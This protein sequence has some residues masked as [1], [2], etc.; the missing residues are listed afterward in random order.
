MREFG[1]IRID[2]EPGGEYPE[3][4]YSAAERAASIA[5]LR[6]I[7][8]AAVHQFREDGFLSVEALLSREDVADALAGLT[9]LATNPSGA[10]VEFESWAAAKLDEVEGEERLDFVRKFHSFV[11]HEERLQRLAMDPELL[12]AVRRMLG[13]EDV[14]LFQDMALLKPPGG[15]R[16]KPF[17]QDHGFFDFKLGTPMVGVWIALD[18]A[19]PE[20]VCMHVVRGSHLEGPVIHF[21]RRDFQICDTSV[22]RSRLVSAPL[23]PGGGLFFDGLLHH[24]TPANRTDRRRRALQFHYVPADALT[25]PDEERLAV[26]GSEGKDVAC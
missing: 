4:L 5:S 17:H 20:N 3:D 23:P 13:A 15:G 10:S 14:V 25:V 24:G 6:D 7:D 2:E 1:S 16:E 8:D 11:D 26:F 22:D 12:R 21:R 9:S 18:E 19:V